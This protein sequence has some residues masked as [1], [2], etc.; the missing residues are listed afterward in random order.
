MTTKQQD[1]VD[2]LM[3]F[4]NGLLHLKVTMYNKDVLI[5]FNKE[6]LLVYKDGDKKYTQ[7]EQ[8]AKPL[9]LPLRTLLRNFKL[10]N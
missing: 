6:S 5:T 4:N 7:D 9:E 3:D 8:T 10:K 2:K 1:F